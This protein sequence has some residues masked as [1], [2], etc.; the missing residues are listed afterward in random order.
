ME[1]KLN[2]K[3]LDKSAVNEV[4]FEK[5]DKASDFE[6]WLFFKKKYC[7][8]SLLKL[9]FGLSTKHFYYSILAIGISLRR[10]KKG[11]AN[12]KIFLA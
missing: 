7:D 12:I 2:I 4:K 10:R 1:I 3:D 11:E 9:C 8:I 5:V 6:N